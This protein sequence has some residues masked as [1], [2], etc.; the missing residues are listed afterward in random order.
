MMR[1]TGRASLCSLTLTIANRVRGFSTTSPRRSYSF[2]L[3][4]NSSISFPRPIARRTTSLHR[5]RRIL[6]PH[7]LSHITSPPLAITHRHRSPS[8]TARRTSSFAHRHS[9]L[10]GIVVRPPAAHHPIST[11]VRRTRAIGTRLLVMF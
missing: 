4:R 3:H 8:T 7:G 10:R 2:A 5:N 6:R 11:I 9:S 1:F